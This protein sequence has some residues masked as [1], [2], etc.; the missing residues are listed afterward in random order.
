LALPHELELEGCG[1]SGDNKNSSKSSN[2]NASHIRTT[3]KRTVV[4]GTIHLLSSL[5]SSSDQHPNENNVDEEKCD[6]NSNITST[7]TTNIVSA[8][9]DAAEVIVVAKPLNVD[10]DIIV[11]QRERS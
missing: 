8:T 9:A 2:P 7:I 4:L 1:C 10:Y 3:P 5:S 11:E 6:D